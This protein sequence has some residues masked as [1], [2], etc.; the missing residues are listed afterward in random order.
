MHNQNTMW[1]EIFKSWADKYKH[2][3]MT[4]I[5]GGRI[6]GGRYGETMPKLE[7]HVVE[8]GRMLLFFDEQE[9]LEVVNPGSVALVAE[10]MPGIFSQK[11]LPEDETLVVR[12]CDR[13]RFTWYS[14]GRPPTSENLC[15]EVYEYDSGSGN[16]TYQEHL[17]WEKEPRPRVTTLEGVDEMLRVDPYPDWRLVQPDK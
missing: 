6:F 8:A 10:L 16:I 15:E 5:M 9:T 2:R 11:G 7:R 4:L 17:S 12:L 1:Q 3:R 13:L 14:Y